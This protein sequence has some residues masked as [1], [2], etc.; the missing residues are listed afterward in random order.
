MWAIYAL[1][2]VTILFILLCVSPYGSGPVSAMSR[3]FYVHIP[4][5][6]YAL[7][8]KIL[9]VQGTAKA[10]YYIMF[11]F[12]EP[13]PFFQMTYLLLSIGGYTV[14]YIYGFEYIPNP[15][16]PEMHKYVGSF[17][18]FIALLTFIAAS[19]VPPGFVTKNSLENNLNLFKYD[20]QLFSPS[21]CQTCKIQK[22]ARSKHCNICGC[23]VSKQDHHC[24]WINQCVGYSNYKYF[25]A[26]I[27][28]HSLI[29]LYAAQC[30]CLILLNI[31]YEENLL[32]AVFTDIHGKKVKSSY[33]I[34][35][36]YMLQRSF[37][38][39]FVIILCLLMGGFS[40]ITWSW[41][42]KT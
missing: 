13:N 19:I 30:G 6:S 29:C 25:L 37:A 17:L 32:T 2:S 27:L 14:F 4:N 35:F 11:I 40:H 12:I 16:V 38:F 5:W 24:I 3:V 22:P 39:V 9:G 20:N 31:I 21:D 34:I 1:I 33:M 41:L 8:T 15:L 18:Y 42:G 10:K 23:C 36:Q 7:T 28:S 26:F